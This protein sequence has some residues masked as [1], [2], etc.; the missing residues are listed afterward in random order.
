MQQLYYADLIL[1]SCV[2]CLV[3]V[4]CTLNTCMALHIIST[5]CGDVKFEERF[6]YSR[7]VHQPRYL[8]RR[9]SI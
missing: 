9:Y 5:R 1:Q 2:V 8:N 6:Y 3:S 4:V 7:T